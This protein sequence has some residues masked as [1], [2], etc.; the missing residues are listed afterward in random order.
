MKQRGIKS[1]MF[2]A[3]DVLQHD[4]TFSEH[5]NAWL[6]EN[7][8]DGMLAYYASLTFALERMSVIT[9]VNQRDFTVT[10]N[11]YTHTR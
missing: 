3:N 7:K 6:M 11:H 2:C 5:G 8:R 1:L 10:H 9:G 4:V